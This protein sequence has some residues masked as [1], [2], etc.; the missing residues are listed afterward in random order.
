MMLSCVFAFLVVGL[1]SVQAQYVDRSEAITRMST[2]LVNLQND[3]DTATVGSATYVDL[4]RKIRYYRNITKDLH[5]GSEVGA[6][7]DKNFGLIPDI[8]ATRRITSPNPVPHTSASLAKNMRVAVE[9]LL[10]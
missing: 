9:Q 3:F 5:R 8:E 2:E 6:A 1:Q 4:G 7:I 10:Q